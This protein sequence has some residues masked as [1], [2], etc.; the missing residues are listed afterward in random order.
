LELQT[1]RVK[2]EAPALLGLEGLRV[3]RG[4]IGRIQLKIPWNKLHTGKLRAVVQQVHLEL[5]PI[6][7]ALAVPFSGSTADLE[8]KLLQELR[9]AKSRAVE[10]RVEQMRDLIKQTE[11]RPDA[12]GHTYFVRLLR[13]IL[14]NIHVDLSELSITLVTSKPKTASS[15]GLELSSLEVVSTDQ[16]FREYL[17]EV[18]VS[19]QSL[20]KLLRLEGLG[21]R[22]SG[23][24]DMAGYALSPSSVRLKL[25]HVPSDQTLRLQ[26]EVAT[27]QVA[28]LNLQKSQVTS[29]G[30]VDF[31]VGAVK[32]LF[33]FNQF[34]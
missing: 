21:L 20:Y 7:E 4:G 9:D 15:V 10:M 24:S 26:F 31:Y 27:Q 25:S 3:R 34:T 1:L 16:T 28:T 30:F 23:S 6:S 17:E 2:A 33:R 8:A 18:T 5:E 19:G 22:I 11:D 32:S 29:L 13:K 12:E 14:N